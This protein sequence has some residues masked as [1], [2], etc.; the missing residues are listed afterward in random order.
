MKN[1]KILTIKI[2]TMQ[3]CRNVL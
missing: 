3:C 1:I 2:V